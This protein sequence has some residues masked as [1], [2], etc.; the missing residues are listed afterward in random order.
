MGNNK[1]ITLQWFA[2]TILCIALTAALMFILLGGAGKEDQFIAKKVVNLPQNWKGATINIDNTDTSGNPLPVPVYDESDPLDP[3]AIDNPQKY[4]DET[5]NELRI[6]IVGECE[7][8]GNTIEP[9][10]N[11]LHGCWWQHEDG[12]IIYSGH[13]V[14]GPRVGTFEIIAQMDEGDELTIEGKRYKIG[15]KMI[16]SNKKLPDFI[17]NEGMFSIVTCYITPEVDRTG[18]YTHNVV[19]TLEEV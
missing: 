4:S 10:R 17:W 7:M 9:P 3:D 11:Y 13:S 2:I 15:A 8:K 14:S 6:P 18:V 19:M 5:A 16:V 12:G 1:Q